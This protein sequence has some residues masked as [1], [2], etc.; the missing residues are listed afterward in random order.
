MV[1]GTAESFSELAEDLGRK[2]NAGHP[3]LAATLL[4]LISKYNMGSF[5]TDGTNST[6]GP[7]ILCCSHL[8]FPGTWKFISCQE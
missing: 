8:N 1:D 4:H 3:F 7:T 2:A 6:P 5:C